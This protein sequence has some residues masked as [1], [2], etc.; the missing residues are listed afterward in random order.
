MSRAKGYGE[1]KTDNNENKKTHH[2]PN[3]KNLFFK[4]NCFA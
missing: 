1:I 4:N 2:A 3:M